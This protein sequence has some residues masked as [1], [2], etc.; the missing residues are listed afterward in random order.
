MPL[1]SSPVANEVLISDAVA[2]VIQFS[3]VDEG[4]QILRQLALEVTG[5]D[6]SDEL[7]AEVVER[8]LEFP[9]YLNSVNIVLDLFELYPVD[10]MFE[11]GGYEF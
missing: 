4:V 9:D 11:E 1:A 2:Q 6:Y 3:D 5:D 10:G 7:L 8:I